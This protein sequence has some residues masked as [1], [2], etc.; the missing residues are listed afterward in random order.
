M[1]KVALYNSVVGVVLNV[2]LALFLAMFAT[3]DQKFPPNGKPQDLSYFDQ[4]MHM[5]VHHEQVLLTSSVIIFAIV[6]L[7]TVI[8]KMLF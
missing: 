1:Y 6:F 7:S 5:L 4:A 2:V 8:A 3:D